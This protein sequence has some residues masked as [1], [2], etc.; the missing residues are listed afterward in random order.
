MKKQLGIRKSNYF[1]PYSSVSKLGVKCKAFF[2]QLSVNAL[3]YNQAMLPT[4]D[5][6]HIHNSDKIK[7]N[8]KPIIN[9]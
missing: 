9:Q 3:F 6:I 5:D 2:Q 1:K 8:R 7:K 4:R